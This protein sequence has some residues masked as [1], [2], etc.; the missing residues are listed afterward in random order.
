MLPVRARIGTRKPRLSL[1]VPGDRVGG[2]RPSFIGCEG[3]LTLAPVRLL[4]LYASK[5]I[6]VPAYRA[7]PDSWRPADTTRDHGSIPASFQSTQ[8]IPGRVVWLQ[9]VPRRRSRSHV[10][11]APHRGRARNLREHDSQ[12]GMA[13]RR[14]ARRCELKTAN[15]ASQ[16]R[17]PFSFAHSRSRAMARRAGPSVT[18]WEILS[19]QTPQGDFWSRLQLS[20]KLFSCLLRDGCRSLRRAFASICRMRS[21]VTSKSCPTSSSV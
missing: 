21:R 2:P 17:A 3:R 20:M 8:P 1:D 11:C 4:S 7:F 18:V 14:P 15:I 9:I 12:R 10:C 5:Q 6:S 13:V 16:R 19:A